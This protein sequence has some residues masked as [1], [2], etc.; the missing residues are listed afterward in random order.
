MKLLSPTQHKRLNEVVGFL[1]LSLGLVLSH[2]GRVRIAL[3][4][5]GTG[6]PH[7]WTLEDMPGAGVAGDVG[8]IEETRLGQAVDRQPGGAGPGPEDDAASRERMT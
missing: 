7:D 2:P 4:N 8:T 1:L 6:A 3:V 5:V